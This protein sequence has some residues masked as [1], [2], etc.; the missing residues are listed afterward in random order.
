[1]A[2]AMKASEAADKRKMYIYAGLIAFILILL[3]IIF[4]VVRRS[5]ISET[6]DY[7][8]GQRVDMIVGDEETEKEI[9][10]SSEELS[11]EEKKRRKMKDELKELVGDQPKEI[12]DIL[13]G[14]LTEE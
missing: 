6:V 1:M 3:L 5:T 7:P 12:A 11:P 9:A 10:I 4:I 2:E 14:W 13:K 8:N